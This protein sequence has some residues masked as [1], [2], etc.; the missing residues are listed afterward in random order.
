M[1]FRVHCLYHCINCKEMV[2][3]DF[4]GILQKRKKIYGII[5]LL[6]LSAKGKI[7]KSLCNRLDRLTKAMN[8]NIVWE[9]GILANSFPLLISQTGFVV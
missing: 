1:L 6:M 7:K 3:A 8:M 2:T 4:V 5:A 9:P